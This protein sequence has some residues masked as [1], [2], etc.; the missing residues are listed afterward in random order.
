[1]KN[2]KPKLIYPKKRKTSSVSIEKKKRSPSKKKK[3]DGSNKHITYVFR[4][5]LQIN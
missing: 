5:H 3:K 4:I 1:M 2:I